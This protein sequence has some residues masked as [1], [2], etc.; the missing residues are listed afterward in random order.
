MRW[1]E[2][3]KNLKHIK[4]NFNIFKFHICFYLK[5]RDFIKF[6]SGCIHSNLFSF[7]YIQIS[8]HSHLFSFQHIQISSHFNSR[9]IS[10]PIMSYITNMSMNI[11]NLKKQSCKV[12]KIKPFT[13]CSSMVTKVSFN[14]NV[15]VNPRYL[16]PL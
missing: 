9:C 14:C 11:M 13:I 12:S 15:L 5:H 1:Y 3:K 8:V 16:S 4:N 2:K 6:S 10:I 7:E